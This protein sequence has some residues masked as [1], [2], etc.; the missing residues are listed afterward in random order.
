MDRWGDDRKAFKAL[1]GG[2]GAAPSPPCSPEAEECL[3]ACTVLDGAETME[4]CAAKGLH[5]GAFHVP[6]NG[7]IF[8][9]LR[10]MHSQQKPL[11]LHV[12]LAE[13]KEQGELDQVGGLAYLLHCTERIPTIAQLAYFLDK[14]FELWVRRT[15]ITCCGKTVEAAYDGTVELSDLVDRHAGRMAQMQG[16][17]SALPDQDATTGAPAAPAGPPRSRSRCESVRPGVEGVAAP[18]GRTWSA[19]QVERT[20]GAEWRPG[21]GHPLRVGHV[22]DKWCL[23][24]IRSFNR[25]VARRIPHKSRSHLKRNPIW[26]TARRLL[27]L[28]QVAD[29]HRLRNA[30]RA[31][32]DPAGSRRGK[33]HEA[34]GIQP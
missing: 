16:A 24:A 22:V 2:Q 29:M 7:I 30:R 11:E 18:V 25:A 21:E 31:T 14:V 6:A 28:P 32:I 5:G 34:G 26:S 33:P 9:R 8:N 27:L 13:L 19:P 12:L 10:A 15:L 20:R 3:I 17:V 23:A 4:K 1:A